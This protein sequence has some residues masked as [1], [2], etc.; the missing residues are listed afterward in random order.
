MYQSSP[1]VTV[2]LLLEHKHFCCMPDITMLCNAAKCCHAAGCEREHIQS[3]Y[4][5]SP[6]LVCA[7]CLVVSCRLDGDLFQ[8][9]EVSIVFLT[10]L[11]AL[12]RQ[13]A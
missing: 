6:Q 12:R 7:G 4:C 2:F 10:M 11:M 13:P 5:W 1:G 8:D 3:K 9:V